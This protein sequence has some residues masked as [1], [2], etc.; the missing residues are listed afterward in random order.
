MVSLRCGLNRL[1][2]KV[3]TTTPLLYE[4]PEP[5]AAVSIA[6][7]EFLDTYGPDL[8]RESRARSVGM[9]RK[10]IQSNFGR[11]PPPPTTTKKNPRF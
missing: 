9:E 6:R 10:A 11:I 8:A 4:F 5:F 1:A 3:L 2:P 7:F